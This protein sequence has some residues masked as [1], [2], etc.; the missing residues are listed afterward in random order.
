MQCVYIK[1]VSNNP[2]FE[3][4]SGVSCM[5][6]FYFLMVSNNPTLNYNLLLSYFETMFLNA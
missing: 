2:Y 4:L 1:T 3:K 6:D 5:Q